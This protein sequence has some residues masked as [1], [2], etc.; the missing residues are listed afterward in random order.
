MHT[1]TQHTHTHL[2]FGCSE[3]GTRAHI[4]QRSRRKMILYSRAMNEMCR[5]WRKKIQFRY[6]HRLVVIDIERTDE[7]TGEHAIIAEMIFS[8]NESRARARA[9]SH[10]N[11][12]Y[13]TLP[14][15]NTYFHAMPPCIVWF[16]I[17]YFRKFGTGTEK[18]L[19]H[20]M[21]TYHAKTNAQKT[22]F[23][24]FIQQCSVFGDFRIK[25]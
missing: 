14:F 23:S 15:S 10:I 21:Y 20:F 8:P 25:A 1:G 4:F 2:R 17:D 7:W 16:F 5:T 3:N 22:Y 6:V 13:V 18:A 11:P 9:H 12:N 24:M 19:M